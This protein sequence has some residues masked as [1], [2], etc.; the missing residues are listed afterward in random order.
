MENFTSTKTISRLLIAGGI[1]LFIPYTILGTIF[2][3]PAILRQDTGI[4]LTKFYE[5]GSKLIWVWFIT[6]DIGCSYLNR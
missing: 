5:G 1:L 3:Y 6:L 4:I 2:D